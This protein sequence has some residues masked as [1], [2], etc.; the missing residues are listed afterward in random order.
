MNEQQFYV[1]HA[2]KVEGPF[3][4]KDIRK[5]L[6]KQELAFHDY[7]WLNEESEW[8]FL[9][10]F[11]Q[12][13]YPP[14]LTPPSGIAEK[15]KKPKLKEFS[16]DTFAQNIGISNEPVWFVYR[17]QTKFGPYR[18]LEVVRLLQK[19]DCSSD[20]FIWKPGFADW[21][22]IAAT[23]EFAEKVLQKMLHVKHFGSEQIFVERRFPRIPYD[24]EVILHDDQRVLFGSAK[25]LSEGGAFVEVPRPTHQ[26]GDRLKIH[27]T[28][29][30]MKAPFNCIAEITQV[31]KTKPVGYCLKFIYLEEEDRKR[32]A[33]FAQLGENGK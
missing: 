17:E 13:D 2:G 27:F 18:Y 31:T 15:S 32:I 6:E 8:A 26:K 9:T 11:F 23:S 22:K 24:G 10:R 3:S 20:D 28:P 4:K 19:K 25:Q 7:V 14:P 12:A 1:S 30:Q 16:E 33:K 5:R 21:Q 29:G